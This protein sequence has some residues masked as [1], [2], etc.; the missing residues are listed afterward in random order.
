MIRRF[1]LLGRLTEGSEV[2]PDGR[3]WHSLGKI[4]SL[5]PKG[6]RQLH[7][8]PGYA[9]EDLARRWEDERSGERRKTLEA[10]HESRRR[11]ERRRQEFTEV[12]ELRLLRSHNR[13]G[14]P[15]HQSRLTTCLWLAALLVPLLAAGIYL[16]WTLPAD[17]PARHDCKAPPA[18]AVDWT[19][20]SF[21]GAR[22]PG[23]ELSRGHLD[24]ADLQGALLRNA[25][26]RQADLSYSN[27]R[28]ADLGGADLSG[29]ILVGADLRDADLSGARLGH[30]DLSFADLRGAHIDGADLDGARF[31][32]TIWV[33]GVACASGSAGACRK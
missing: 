8:N 2:S 15:P 33:D 5:A 10:V 26:L 14:I 30:A 9:A 16:A 22:L 23:A 6:R 1:V 21:K 18:P 25:R 32:E 20:C 29:A 28:G 3:S 11:R 17:V 13:T 19:R 7:G 24:D 27:L 31:D 4:S 12:V